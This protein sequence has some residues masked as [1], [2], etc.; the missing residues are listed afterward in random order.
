MSLYSIWCK[1]CKSFPFLSGS[2]ENE[3]MQSIQ[4]KGTDMYMAPSASECSRSTIMSPTQLA[5][6]FQDFFATCMMSQT[7]GKWE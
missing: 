6:H 1:K 2:Y 4:L 3:D 5:T 7:E